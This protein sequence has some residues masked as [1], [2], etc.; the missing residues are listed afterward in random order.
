MIRAAALL[1]AV[2]AASA[3]A[4]AQQPD[5][6]AAERPEAPRAELCR[7]LTRHVPAAGVAFEPGVDVRGKPVVP[8]EV[9]G[10]P[11]FTVPRRFT[12]PITIDLA[13]QLNVPYEAETLVATVIVEGDRV[14]INGREIGADRL[15]AVC[16]EVG[17][18]V[19]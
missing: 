15:S 12:L 19:E 8:P 16:R 14:L 5:A 9:E 3:P 11:G 17:T 1:L 4:A 2:F 18:D 7:F 10:A 6:D 13:E